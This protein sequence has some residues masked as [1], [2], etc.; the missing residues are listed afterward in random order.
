MRRGRRSA[1]R[2]SRVLRPRRHPLASIVVQDH[3]S[4]PPP[5]TLSP[6]RKAHS[7][8][9][10]PPNRTKGTVGQS[11]SG[12]DSG[13]SPQTGPDLRPTGQG[14]HRCQIG[15]DVEQPGSAEAV[16]DRSE[17]RREGNERCGTC[18]LRRPA[19]YLKKNEDKKSKE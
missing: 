4:V 10:P 1:P 5:T 8:P 18:K 12:R 9:P 16:V 11:T 13:S 7:T 6:P 2:R 17:A 14:P 15:L 3:R 19:G